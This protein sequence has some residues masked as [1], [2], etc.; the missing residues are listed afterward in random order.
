MSKRK[1]HITDIQKGVIGEFSK[2][3]E[4]YDELVDANRQGQKLMCLC[5]I[6][7]LI[8]ALELY[9]ENEYGFNLILQP[10]NLTI[11]PINDAEVHN[12]LE[13]LFYELY[14]LEFCKNDKST[15]NK[16]DVIINTI[17]KEIITL[18]RYYKSFD[19]SDVLAFTHKTIESFN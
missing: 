5:E 13:M 3:W 16:V 14:Y 17:N 15:R 7:D 10:S 6:C 12:S 1:Y 9:I 2:I 19:M 11:E 4:E 18:L 8:G